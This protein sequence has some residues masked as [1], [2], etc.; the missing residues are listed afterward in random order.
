MTCSSSSWQC[1]LVVGWG[2]KQRRC[3]LLFVDEDG[4]WR[5][6]HVPIPT[7]KAGLVKGKTSA[8]HGRSGLFGTSEGFGRS[9][10]W[11]LTQVILHR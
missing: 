7:L 4:G 9:P 2:A 8:I 6:E 5:K 3:C 1:C 11:K 10:P